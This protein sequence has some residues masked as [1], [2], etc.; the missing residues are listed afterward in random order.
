MNTDLDTL[1][2]ALYVALTDD[3]IPSLAIGTGPGR[4]AEV[5]D[6][7]EAQDHLDRP[8]GARSTRPHPAQAVRAHRIVSPGTLLR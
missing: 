7:P 2:I 1:L 3:I 5:T 8:R 6:A 4:P